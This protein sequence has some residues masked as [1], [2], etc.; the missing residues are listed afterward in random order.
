MVNKLATTI[1]ATAVLAGAGLFSGFA[2]IG[3][4]AGQTRNFTPVEGATLK[5]KMESAVTA[6][7]ANAPGG[8]FWVAY[9]FEARPGVAVDFEVVDSS[10]GVYISMDGTSVSF[11]P[12]YETRE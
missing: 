6:G 12:R 5:A 3:S 9:Q 2:S 7:R 1:F 4:A 11:D 8:R 10:G